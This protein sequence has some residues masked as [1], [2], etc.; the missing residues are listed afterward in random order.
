M[1]Y[2]LSNTIKTYPN[3]KIT[4]KYVI[5]MFELKNF[6]VS[7]ENGQIIKGID[8][9][10]K[11]GETH[12]IMG[13]NG[14]GKSTL[15]SSLLGHPNFITHGKIL[16]DNEDISLLETDA[17]AR[18][19]MFLI[20]QY[21]EEIEGITVSNV[22][23]KASSAIGTKNLDLDKL[24]EQHK[25][26]ESDATA[27]G[28]GKEFIKRELNVGFSGGEKKRMEMLQAM[29]LNPKFMI[30][31]EIDSGLDVD[32]LRIISSTIEQ[33]KDGKRN[34]LIITHYP[35]ILKHLKVDYVHILV[36]GKIVK[37]G[38]SALAEEIEEKGYAPYSKSD[39]E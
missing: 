27:L 4:Y 12:V 13:P 35:R 39:D 29:A 10:I 16:L 2:I 21:P 14:A 9:T 33:M 28:L 18:K 30:I 1:L 31:D 24:V 26:L 23:R 17:R 37:T 19:G 36:D 11:D 22:I 38:S 15:A 20:F 6:S 8:L 32:G 25:K 34:F 7:V 3:T 5:I